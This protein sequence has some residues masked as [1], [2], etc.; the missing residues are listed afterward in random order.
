MEH[1]LV[2][3]V[4]SSNL[5][6]VGGGQLSGRLRLEQRWRDGQ[7][8]TGWRLRPSLRYTILF[9]SRNKVG[10]TL[11]EEPFFDLN[12]TSFQSVHGLEST[13]R[14]VAPKSVMDRRRCI[15]SALYPFQTMAA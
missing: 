12:T 8:G 7:T 9:T 3:H 13:S 4:V 10:L 11:S 15:I 1:R 6:K 14:I 5:G 2:E